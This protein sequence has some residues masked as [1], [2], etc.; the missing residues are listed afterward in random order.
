M[1]AP[2]YKY[3]HLCILYRRCQWRIFCV[4]MTLEPKTRGWSAF[5]MIMRVWMK[6]KC[7]KTCFWGEY[8][9]KNVHYFG[10]TARLPIH[11]KFSCV[12]FS[13]VGFLEKL[14]CGFS[15]YFMR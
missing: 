5:K 11:P 3:M 15:M 8:L 12:L 4:S 1:H 9:N 14:K 2:A 10:N 7:T 6:C 13:L